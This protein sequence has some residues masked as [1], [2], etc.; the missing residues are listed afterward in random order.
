[1]SNIVENLKQ[2]RKRIKSST[3]KVNR[4]PNEV[5]IVAVTKT[6][7]S[8]T[9]KKA[10]DIGIK[11]IGEIKVQ[12]AV[13]KQKELGNL[14]KK[15]KWHMIGHL[16]SNKVKFAVK[17]FDMIQ[18]IDRMKIAKKIS[19]YCVRFKKE[20][21]VLVQ[22]NLSGKTHGV[23]PENTVNFVNKIK[24]LEGIKVK[25]LMGIAPYTTDNEN[26]RP[27]FRKLKQLSQKCELNYLSMGMSNDYTVAIEEGATIIRIGTA[28]FGKR[29]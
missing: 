27:Y 1:M 13:K 5:T 23:K 17:T 20:L 29:G 15:V 18:A 12:E 4:H 9:I 8:S 11:N 26:C 7:G 22:V 21:P 6:F 24:D 10:I 2:I 28:I 3:Q 25:G 16:Q 14:S 19:D